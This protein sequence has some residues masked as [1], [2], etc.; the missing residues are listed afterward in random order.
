MGDLCHSQIMAKRGDSGFC[1]TQQD[2]CNTDIILY[3]AR[4][5]IA[6]RQAID[7]LMVLCTT[8]ISYQGFLEVQ[9]N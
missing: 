9:K 3:R 2:H 5:H 8:G 1:D 4:K 6:S 7:Q